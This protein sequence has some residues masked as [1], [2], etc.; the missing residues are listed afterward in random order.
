[1]LYSSCLGRNEPY[2]Q[3]I[4]GSLSLQLKWLERESNHEPPNYA[5]VK[6]YGASPPLPLCIY[7]CGD[8][9]EG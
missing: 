3:W 7:V 2:M 6:V 5:E 4:L 9:V 8:K 1:M